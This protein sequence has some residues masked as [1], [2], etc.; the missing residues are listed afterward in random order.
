L[1]DLQGKVLQ[2]FRGH[3]NAVTSLAFSPNGQSITTWSATD[4][5][6]KSWNLQGKEWQGKALQN[7][8]DNFFEKGAV[9]FSLSGKTIHIGFSRTYLHGECSVF[10]PR[11]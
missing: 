5:L 7:L 11:W 1:W 3:T 6:T 9:F 2:T 10:F 4:E 8:K